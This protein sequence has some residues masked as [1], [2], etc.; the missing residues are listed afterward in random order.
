MERTYKVEM[1]VVIDD[2]DL[3]GGKVADD[4]VLEALEEAPF[5]VNTVCCTTV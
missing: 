1:E 2:E 3:T 5:Q 4:I